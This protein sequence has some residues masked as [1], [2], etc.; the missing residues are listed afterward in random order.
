MGVPDVSLLKSFLLGKTPDF[1]HLLWRERGEEGY[2]STTSVTLVPCG[3]CLILAS[4]SSHP[5]R[6][7]LLP[8]RNLQGILS[9]KSV[10]FWFWLHL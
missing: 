4:L 8:I 3:I 9:H 10:L 2:V 1:S 7:L 5:Q 6:Y